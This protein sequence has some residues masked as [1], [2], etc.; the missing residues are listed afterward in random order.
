MGIIMAAIGIV[1]GWKG[2]PFFNKALGLAVLI[3][4]LLNA[5]VVYQIYES[6]NAEA[7]ANAGI[8]TVLGLAVG[9]VCYA[10]CYV[11]FFYLGKKKRSRPD[12]NRTEARS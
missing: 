10:I 1:M 9:F 7:S 12:A 8:G 11:I 4:F 5:Y 6:G 3:L 2:R